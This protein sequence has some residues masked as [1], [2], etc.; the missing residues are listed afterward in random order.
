[1]KTFLGI[2]AGVTIAVLALVIGYYFVRLIGWVYKKLFGDKP[3]DEKSQALQA[4]ELLAIIVLFLGSA[5]PACVIMVTGFEWGMKKYEEAYP[6]DTSASDAEFEREWTYYICL[7]ERVEK[8]DKFAQKVID[9]YWAENENTLLKDAFLCRDER[10]MRQMVQDAGNIKTEMILALNTSGPS[11]TRTRAWST[12][13][14]TETFLD[15]LA[16]NFGVRDMEEELVNDPS[17][18]YGSLLKLEEQ[19]GDLLEK[20]L[21]DLGAKQDCVSGKSPVDGTPRKQIRAQSN[22]RPSPSEAL[23]KD[24]QELLKE[25]ETLKSEGVCELPL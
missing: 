18:R 22:S 17:F 2:I 10:L 20:L 25:L 8:W 12:K 14:K 3:N 11:D 5:V 15:M 6:P 23:E 1:M 21:A 4:A 13:K 16:E 24:I 19:Y 9:L 7:K